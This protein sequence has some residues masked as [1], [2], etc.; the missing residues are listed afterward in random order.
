MSLL[1]TQLPGN[2][3]NS[4]EGPIGNA[5]PVLTKS[6]IYQETGIVIWYGEHWRGAGATRQSVSQGRL[7]G[8]GVAPGDS[9]KAGRGELTKWTISRVK[10]N[11]EV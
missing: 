1:T 10:E 4:L 6:H 5:E 8:G 11:K 9:W 3:S 2:L 7:P